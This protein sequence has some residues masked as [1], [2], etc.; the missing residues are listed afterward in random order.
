M[1]E[2]NKIPFDKLNKFL[3]KINSRVLYVGY[4]GHG[5][6]RIGPGCFTNIDGWRL[7]QQELKKQGLALLKNQNK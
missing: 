2:E 7:F 6:Y 4:I 3:E 1:K 5:I